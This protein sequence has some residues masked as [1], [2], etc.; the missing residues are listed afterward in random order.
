MARYRDT[1]RQ[2]ET[3]SDRKR[4]TAKDTKTGDAGVCVRR[5]MADTEIQ[6]N[7]DRE[8]ERPKGTE[9][10]TQQEIPKQAMRVCV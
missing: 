9:R 8:R 7:R 1:E 5:V 2:I 3:E 6:R 10:D 4:H